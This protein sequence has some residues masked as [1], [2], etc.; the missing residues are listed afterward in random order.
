MCNTIKILF[1]ICFKLFFAQNSSI[2]KFFQL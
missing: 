2:E 1:H